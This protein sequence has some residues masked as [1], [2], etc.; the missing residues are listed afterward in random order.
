MLSRNYGCILLK[1]RWP[2]M[3]LD[4]IIDQFSFPIDKD[5]TIMSFNWFHTFAI[6]VGNIYN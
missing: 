4:I 2:E 6:I 1:Q 5:I 3:N